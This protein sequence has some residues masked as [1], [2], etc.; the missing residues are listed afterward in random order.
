MAL[1]VS[2]PVVPQPSIALAATSDTGVRGDGVTRQARPRFTGVAPA[3]SSVYVSADGQLLGIARANP[4]GVWALA[5]PLAV[6][7]HTITA[8]A[9]DASQVSSATTTFSM[10]VD[11]TRPTA[12]LIYDPTFK[13]TP[14]GP[15]TG[16]VTVTFSEPVQGVSL[17]KMRFSAPAMGIS[18]PLAS[19]MLANYVGAITTSQLSDRSYAFTP[20]VQ[21]FA[22]GTYVLAFVKTGVMDAA[23]NPL[24]ANAVTRFTVA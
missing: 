4:R 20:A 17:A 6:G 22:P 10:S 16:R 3:Q 9:V 11:R 13:A 14:T 23:G 5:R 8:Y 18:V 24:A 2:T 19:P 1:T 21:A 7:S 12:S 15:V